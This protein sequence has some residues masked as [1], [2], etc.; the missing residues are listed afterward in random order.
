MPATNVDLANSANLEASIKMDEVM[1]LIVSIAIPILLAIISLPVTV[2]RIAMIGMDCVIV[3]DSVMSTDSN[4]NHTIKQEVNR[5]R[6]GTSAN[7]GISICC[8]I[9]G[10]VITSIVVLIT[11]AFL[12]IKLFS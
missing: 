8:G 1:D 7:V 9:G 3:K 10:A 6:K 12:A 4:T 5:A 11:T 2:T